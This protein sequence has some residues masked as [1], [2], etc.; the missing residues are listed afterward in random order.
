MKH[1]RRWLPN[2]SCS[3]SPGTVSW[4]RW[5]IREVVTNV[6]WYTD[7]RNDRHTRRK[8]WVMNIYL[9]ESSLPR[10]TDETSISHHSEPPILSQPWPGQIPDTDRSQPSQWRCAYTNIG[11]GRL[12][13]GAGQLWSIRARARP[14][15]GGDGHTPHRLR[16]T[17]GT[18][19]PGHF[20]VPKVTAYCSK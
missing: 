7:H 19:V 4:C 1:N 11:K 2:K 12:Q 5:T 3:G 9:S 18:H 13:G 20:L 17:P 8:Y 14:G 16:P 15:G 6:Q 10:I